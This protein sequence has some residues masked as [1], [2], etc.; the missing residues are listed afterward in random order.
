MDSDAAV[1]RVGPTSPRWTHIAIPTSDLDASIAWYER[2][3]PLRLLDRRS[4]SQ[5]QS[6]WVG[7]PD[8][9]GR[10]FVLVLVAFD[11]DRDRGPLPTLAPFAHIGIELPTKQAV[12]DIADMARADGCL[13]WE[14]QQMADHVGFIC[15]CHDPDHNVVEFSFDQGVYEKAQ[16]VW[17][18]GS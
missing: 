5:G 17:G 7:D 14:P 16:E 1:T 2:Y 3:T 12:C 6:A 9:A 18:T 15:A 11:R 4:D 13:V 10:P 8:S